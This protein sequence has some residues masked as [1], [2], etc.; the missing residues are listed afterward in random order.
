M[1]HFRRQY[2]LISHFSFAQPSVKCQANNFFNRIKF[3]Q[4]IYHISLCNSNT[5]F[6]KIIMWKT[7]S[8]QKLSVKENIIIYQ[9]YW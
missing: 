9:I 3:K 1:L 4:I 5:S 7:M 2:Y 6:Y 8:S